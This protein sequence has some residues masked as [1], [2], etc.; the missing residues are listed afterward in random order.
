MI[1]T[2]ASNVSALMIS[3]ICWSAMLSP[4]TGSSGR[5]ET[6][7]LTEVLEIRPPHFRIIDPTVGRLRLP[8]H[9]DVLSN[10]KILEQRRFLV[11]HGNPGLLRL[12]RRLK[13]HFVPVHTDYAFVGEMQ[14]GHDFDQGA[15]AAPFSPISECTSPGKR[16]RLTPSSTRVLPNDL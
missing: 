12:G 3:T 10:G 2:L 14:P 4:N 5:S 1:S 6:P 16:E 8:M 11:N 7:N 9:E 13:K 15:F